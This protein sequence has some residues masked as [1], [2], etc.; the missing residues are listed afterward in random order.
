MFFLNVIR[1]NNL[2]CL[3]ADGSIIDQ[4]GA[5]KVWAGIINIK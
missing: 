5:D 1:G 4:I 3:V 2:C